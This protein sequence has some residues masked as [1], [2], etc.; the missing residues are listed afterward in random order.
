MLA[1]CK[2]RLANSP[3]QELEEARE[4][5]VLINQIR[6]TKLIDEVQ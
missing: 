5:L 2:R 4:Q 6:V 3:E 1:E